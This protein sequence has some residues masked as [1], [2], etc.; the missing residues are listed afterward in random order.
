M[1]GNNKKI[2]IHKEYI[3]NLLINQSLSSLLKQL[4]LQYFK[5]NELLESY[6]SLSIKEKQEKEKKKYSH[7]TKRK[8]FQSSVANVIKIII[9]ILSDTLLYFIMLFKFKDMLGI[10]APYQKLLQNNT[11]TS[12]NVNL[13]VQLKPS[14]ATSSFNEHSDEFY[15]AKVNLNTSKWAKNDQS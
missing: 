11:N 5:I 6:R 3:L 12:E 13:N 4:Y 8:I 7:T 14:E 1:V 9:L 2:K 15:T 10:L